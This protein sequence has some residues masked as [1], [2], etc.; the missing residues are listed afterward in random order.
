VAEYLDPVA[1]RLARIFL[2]EPTVAIGGWLK[3][4]VGTMR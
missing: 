1:E 4:T 3:T 2:G